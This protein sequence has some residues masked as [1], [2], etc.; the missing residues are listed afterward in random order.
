[1]VS[2]DIMPHLLLS[3]L[4]L[5]AS[6]PIFHATPLTTQV[7]IEM[8]TP[9][10]LFESD[11]RDH[12]DSRR[13]LQLWDITDLIGTNATCPADCPLCACIPP[14]EDGN[15]TTTTEIDTN[16]LLSASIEACATNTFDKCYAD[17]LG[18][19]GDDVDIQGLCSAQ[20]DKPEEEIPPSFKSVCRV[21]DIFACCNE[22]P[23]ER[24]AECF[25]SDIEDGYT[26]VG[27]EPAVCSTTNSSIR[28]GAEMKMFQPLPL[29]ILSVV[30]ILLG[31]L[32]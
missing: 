31:A 4:L 14:T 26:P 28:K 20:C 10:N 27:W 12:R 32:F 21:C 6:V 13:K 5:A 29:P 15:S 11:K 8:T 25:P 30:V 16:C 18:L 1:M 24:S 17:L 3:L 2:S 23:S 19:F 22:C 7:A 9:S